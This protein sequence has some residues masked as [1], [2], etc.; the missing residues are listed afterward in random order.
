[1]KKTL[2]LVAVA[3]LFAFPVSSFADTLTWSTPTTAGNTN[4]STDNLNESD[5]AG[6]ANQFDLDH[7]R[8]YSWQIGGVNLNGKTITSATITFKNIA[9]WDTNTNKLFVHL[10]NTG[11]SYATSNATYGRTVTTNGVT[12]YQDSPSDTTILDHFSSTSLATANR[13]GVGT[14]GDNTFLFEQ[15]FN[16][17]GQAGYVAQD[18]TYTFNAAQ[19]AALASYIAA[20]N[21][22][23]FG[24][25]PD[26]HFWNNGITFNIVTAVPTPEPVSM[27]LLGTGLAGLYI[28]KRRRR[29]AA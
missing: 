22:I 8:A 23:A 5:Y 14:G 26:C 12:S 29:N 25:D 9:N 18:Y 19:L 20:G 13:L 11:T 6:G 21:N 2:L 27:V 16:K 7:T 28:K 4:N 17:V 1:V 24:F 3:A 15:S 10:F